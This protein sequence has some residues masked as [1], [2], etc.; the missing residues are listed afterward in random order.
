[1][2]ADVQRIAQTMGAEWVQR[3][4]ADGQ[5]VLDAFRRS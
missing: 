3:A 5:A 4:G 2:M 1:M